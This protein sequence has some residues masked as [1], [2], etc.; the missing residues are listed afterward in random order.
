[1]VKNIFFKSAIVCIA[2]LLTS[3]DQTIHEY[4][5][6]MNDEIEL[7]IVLNPDN[8]HNVTCDIYN[9]LITRPT[10]SSEMMRVLFYAP[11][12]GSLMSQSFISQKTI[13]SNGYEVIYGKIHLPPGD[14]IM[15]AYNFDIET[16]TIHNENDLSGI[17]ATTPT[18]TEYLGVPMRDYDDESVRCMPEHLLVAHRNITISPTCDMQIVEAEA[19]TVIDTYYLQ[20]KV[21]GLQYAS[22]AKATLSGMSPSN[23]IGSDERTRANTKIMFDLSG[24]QDINI[25]GDNKDVLCSLF[26]TFG[27]VEGIT[28]ELTVRFDIITN[29]GTQYAKTIDISNDFLSE[30]ARERHWL[31]IDYVLDIPEPHN[32]GGGFNPDMND[33][34]ISD[35]RIDIF[36]INR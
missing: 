2:M 10:I 19:R 11:S 29:D 26:N 23:L 12:D 33:W 8:V 36:S 28:S 30:D 27:K 1:M 7:R 22:K 6:E 20:I 21:R 31:L 35:D 18:I 13:N 3:C 15:L 24:G 16:V 25:A 4:P 32:P 5:V 17:V 14:Y 34:E 9:D